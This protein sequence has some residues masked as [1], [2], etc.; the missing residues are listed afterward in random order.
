MLPEV[1]R[2]R[3]RS[4]DVIQYKKYVLFLKRNFVK[5]RFSLENLSEQS[6]FSLAINISLHAQFVVNLL[7]DIAYQ[8]SKESKVQPWSRSRGETLR[9]FFYG[10]MF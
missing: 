8:I 7:T 6:T 1:W 10:D 2:R 9:N 4:Y 5:S 3:R